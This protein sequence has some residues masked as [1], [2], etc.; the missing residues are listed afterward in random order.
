LGRTGFLGSS[1]SLGINWSLHQ[2]DNVS[3]SVVRD[4]DPT[5]YQLFPKKPKSD[6]TGS[7]AQQL[8]GAKKA[9]RFPLGRSVFPE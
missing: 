7:N 1:L 8:S 3:G 4:G 9:R 2:D 6:L 5:I